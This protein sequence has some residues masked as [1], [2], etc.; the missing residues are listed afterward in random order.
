MKFYTNKVVATADIS[1][2]VDVLNSRTR[3]GH[4]V[5]QERIE[6]HLWLVRIACTYRDDADL[7]RG[8]R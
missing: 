7:V 8:L 4:I 6:R 1:N 5:H 2:L 3:D